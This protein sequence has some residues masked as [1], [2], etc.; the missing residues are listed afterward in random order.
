MHYLKGEVD[1]LPAYR[2][3]GSS[4]GMLA[5]RCGFVIKN[6]AEAGISAEIKEG[7]SLA[8]G[9]SLPDETLPTKLVTIAVK[10]SLEEF[11]RRLRLGS[12]PVLGYSQE[13]RFVFDLRTV[14]PSQDEDLLKAIV[15]AYGA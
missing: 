15:A 12:P 6:L 3:M 13:G 14:F 9:G 4:L 2:M 10:G 1:E 7:Q 8:G 11:S 5:Q